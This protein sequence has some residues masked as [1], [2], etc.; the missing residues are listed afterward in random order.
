MQRVLH[1]QETALRHGRDRQTPRER[2]NTLYNTGTQFCVELSFPVRLVWGL[3]L[4]RRLPTVCNKCFTYMKQF[5]ATDKTAKRPADSTERPTL[6]VRMLVPLPMSPCVAR[7]RLI[8]R[9]DE[10]AKV[11]TYTSPAPRT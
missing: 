6:I 9:K 2:H 4:Q 10:K 7:S 8:S 11:E 3:C 5:P 1:P